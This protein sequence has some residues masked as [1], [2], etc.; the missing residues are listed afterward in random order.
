MLYYLGF[1]TKLW[2]N[3]PQMDACVS[4]LLSIWQPDIPEMVWKG[5]KKKSL[6]R[7]DLLK[8]LAQYAVQ[9]VCLLC[10]NFSH[11]FASN[12]RHIR[13]WLRGLLENVVWIN[14]FVF[15]CLAVYSKHCKN[16]ALSCIIWH[17]LYCT[18]GDPPWV[19]STGWAKC[20]L[21]K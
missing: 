6:K 2:E 4:S 8:N 17:A 7:S 15:I 14:I 11:C 13:N 16:I 9:S 21:K 18:Q 12:F 5:G 19:E 1:L 3:L 20:F 10:T